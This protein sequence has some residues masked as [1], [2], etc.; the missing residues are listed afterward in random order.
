[1][2]TRYRSRIWLPSAGLFVATALLAS[3]CGGSSSTRP[4]VAPAVKNAA[5]PDVVSSSAVAQRPMRG[6]GGTEINDD[7]PAQAD[8]GHGGGNGVDDPCKL[9][10]KTQA[11]A[12]IGEPI[13]TPQEAPLGPTCIYQPLHANRPVTVVVESINFA[14]ARSQIR[15]P[16]KVTMGSRTAYCG[17]YGHPTTLVPLTR[18]WVLNVTAPCAIGLQFAAKA[19]TQL[20]V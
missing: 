9:V 20:K 3:A 2:A 7:N 8:S 15:H 12:I 11:Q 13:G 18:G 16:I 6:T 19:L 17:A 4:P 5:H 1:M 10:S 14:R